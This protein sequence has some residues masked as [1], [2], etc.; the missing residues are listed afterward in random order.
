MGILTLSVRKIYY[1]F[2]SMEEI[3]KPMRKSIAV[4]VGTQRT[5]RYT[6]IVVFHRFFREIS[7][8]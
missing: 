6:V 3:K 7:P 8:K 2:N 4:K 1:R 5:N